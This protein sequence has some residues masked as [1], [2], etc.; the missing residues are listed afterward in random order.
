M[1]ELFLAAAILSL[2]FAPAPFPKRTR[3]APVV[4]DAKQIQGTWRILSRTRGG[5]PVSHVVATAEIG[6]GRLTLVNQ[7]GTWRSPFSLT[8][9]PTKKPRWFDTKSEKNNYAKRGIYD[10]QGDTLKLVYTDHG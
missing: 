3:P 8:L 7:A 5:Q 1:R 6:A 10:L 2:A 9:D 4:D